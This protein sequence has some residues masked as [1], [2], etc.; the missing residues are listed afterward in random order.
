MMTHSPKPYRLNTWVAQG[1]VTLDAPSRTRVEDAG[2]HPWGTVPAAR[3]TELLKLAGRQTTYAKCSFA[4]E[5][6]GFVVA[7]ANSAHHFG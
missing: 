3:L 4:I 6:L 5:F 2:D 1:L 7:F